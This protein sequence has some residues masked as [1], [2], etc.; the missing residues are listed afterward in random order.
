MLKK[1]FF[2]ILILVLFV[3]ICDYYSSQSFSNSTGAP[4]GYTGSPFDIGNCAA[5]HPHTDSLIDT[6]NWMTTDVPVYGYNHTMFYN[7]TVTI[8]QAG[9]KGFEASVQDF[10]GYQMG[11]MMAGTNT[12]IIGSG[13]YITHTAPSSSNP[14][15]W[16]FQWTPSMAGYGGANIYGAFT[17]DSNET[18]IQEIP[19]IEEPCEHCHDDVPSFYLDNTRFYSFCT[20]DAVR[21][22]WNS[23]FE[24]HI[25][26]FLFSANGTLI[27]SKK[28]ISQHA[29][30]NFYDLNSSNISTG[31]YI[32]LLNNGDSSLSSK[33]FISN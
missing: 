8:P 20:G 29:G 22:F 28:N 5:C 1:I 17:T 26:I 12:Q 14:Q 24:C 10:S 33:I 32:I 7:F 31:V 18:Y 6:V 19:L 4:E 13:K 2:C 15:T 9:L 25:N 27:L 23:W 3:F 21:V 30:L 16:S 11:Y